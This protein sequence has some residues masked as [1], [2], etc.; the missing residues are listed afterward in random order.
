MYLS[1]LPYQSSVLSIEAFGRRLPYISI[2][3][4]H[5]VSSG[6]QHA[7]VQDTGQREGMTESPM[8]L[9]KPFLKDLM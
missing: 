4:E 3:I 9:T 7:G 6:C 1:M 5:G 2:V 8:W